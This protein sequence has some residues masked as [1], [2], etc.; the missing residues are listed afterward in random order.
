MKSIEVAIGTGSTKWL[1]FFPPIV[2]V[3]PVDGRLVMFVA[4]TL[5]YCSK[6]PIMV[7]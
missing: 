4:H 1:H 2:R 5:K 6:K 7:A 3:T